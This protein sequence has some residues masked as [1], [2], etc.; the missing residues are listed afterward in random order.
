MQHIASDRTEQ[1]P[2]SQNSSAEQSSEPNQ[3]GTEHNS[4][5]AIGANSYILNRTNEP[6][7]RTENQSV[8]QTTGRFPETP[9]LPLPL[10]SRIIGVPTS[11]TFQN[12]YLLSSTCF[13]APVSNETEKSLKRGTKSHKRKKWSPEQFRIMSGRNVPNIVFGA[14]VFEILSG[15]PVKKKVYCVCIR[16]NTQTHERGARRWQRNPLSTHSKNGTTRGRER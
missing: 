5:S 14:G 7:K 12:K 8:Y 15:V 11:G 3:A 10:A 1:G 2:V 16:L 6:L 13:R 9:F 4:D